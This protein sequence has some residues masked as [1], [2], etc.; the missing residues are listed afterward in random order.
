MRDLKIIMSV[1]EFFFY[2]KDLLI[3]YDA[4]MFIENK[5]TNTLRPGYLVNEDNID[6]LFEKYQEKNLRFFITTLNLNVAETDLSFYSD[7][8]FP[9]TI[10]GTGG[11]ENASEIEII[12][13]R[14]LAKKPE[15]A[16]LSLYNAIRNRLKKDDEINGAVEVLNT[17]YNGYFYKASSVKNKKVKSDFYND[18]SPMYTPLTE[19]DK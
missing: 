6:F 8:I 9:S 15:K 16:V 7:E 19:L 10:E 4:Q 2:I 5:I 17:V 1:K 11:R 3:K 18:K 12:T 13:L 14:R